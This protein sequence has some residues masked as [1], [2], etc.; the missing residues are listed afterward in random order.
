MT[1]EARLG[2]EPPLEVDGKDAVYVRAETWNG[3]AGMLYMFELKHGMVRQGCCR[4]SGW[5]MERFDKDT[6]YVQDGT[7]SCSIRT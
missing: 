4:G 2:V 3:S 6:V 7:W 5:N 1:K